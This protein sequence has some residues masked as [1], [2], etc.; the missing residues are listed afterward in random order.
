MK[1]AIDAMG[2]DNAPEEIVDGAMKAALD[3]NDI[4]IT[5]VGNEDEIRKY[6]TSNDDRIQV[7]HTNEMILGTDEPVRAVRR[8]NKHQWC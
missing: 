3:F 8:K 6:L 2:G 1:I 5:L 4:E 7:L